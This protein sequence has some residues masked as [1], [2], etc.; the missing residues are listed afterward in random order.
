MLGEDLV[1]VVLALAVSEGGDEE[2]GLE[3]VVSIKKNKKA[4]RSHRLLFALSA[5]WSLSAGLNMAM[6]GH[7]N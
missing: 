5:C 7:K 3:M 4:R 2:L 6:P 1:L